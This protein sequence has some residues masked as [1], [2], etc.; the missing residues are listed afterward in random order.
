M[1]LTGRLRRSEYL[2]R[3]YPYL[4][5]T[6]LDSHDSVTEFSTRQVFGIEQ[7]LWTFRTWLWRRRARKWQVVPGSI[8]GREFLRLATN[9]G[10]LSLSYTY[11]FDRQVFS[12]ELRKWIVSRKTS[13]AESDPDTIEF[14]RR[15]PVGSQIRVRV[16]PQQPARS[17]VDN[18]A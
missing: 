5:M 9:A 6:I 18:F 13:K 16:D 12:G 14:S 11:T 7:L 3:F 1:T 15:F 4:P 10:W 17:V 8:A 2:F